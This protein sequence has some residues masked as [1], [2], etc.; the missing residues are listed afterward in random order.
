MSMVGGRIA[1]EAF[2]M[3]SGY[4]MFMIL[5]EKYQGEGRLRRFF[6]SRFLRIFPLY[7]LIALLSGFMMYALNLKPV[8]LWH[9]YV[10][11]LPLP[12]LLILLFTHITLIGQDILVFVGVD[13]SLAPQHPGHA[14]PSTLADFML[15]PT[16]WTLSLELYFYA[17]APW[18]ARARTRTLVLLMAG[19]ILLKLITIYVLGL[20]ADF[21]HYRF[22]PSELSF[23]LA[24]GIAY[25]MIPL[26]EHQLQLVW[27]R[28]L[29]LIAVIATTVLFSAIPIMEEVKSI[30][31][32]AMIFAALPFLFRATKHSRIDRFIG[33]MSYPIYLVH[34]LIIQM[35]SMFRLGLT[36]MTAL[37]VVLLFAA[38][39][40]FLFEAPINAWRQ[41]LVH[42]TRTIMFPRLRL[43]CAMCLTIGGCVYVL[44]STDR[45]PD[46]M[47]RLLMIEWMRNLKHQDTV[48]FTDGDTKYK[49]PDFVE[50]LSNNDLERMPLRNELVPVLYE[51]WLSSKK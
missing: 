29:T 26:I 12:Q 35:L 27:P 39:F 11:E 21:W 38:A 24:G 16:A 6:R 3:I 8:S 9:E 48:M 14:N 4:Y 23:F 28:L 37:T 49:P 25:R 41:R 15:V 17:I 42:H 36:Y 7:L 30:A 44:V 5:T 10:P 40:V 33:E 47:Q 45:K 22:F 1:V 20:Q 50:L 34:L 13:P 19:S 32:F 18:L 43:A 2:F 46:D 31:Y 51:A